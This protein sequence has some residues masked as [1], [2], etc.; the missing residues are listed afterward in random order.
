MEGTQYLTKEAVFVAHKR[1]RV[2]RS[3]MSIKLVV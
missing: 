1:S 2:S 3:G